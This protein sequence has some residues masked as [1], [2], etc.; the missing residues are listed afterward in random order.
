MWRSLWQVLRGGHG[1]RII[2]AVAGVFLG[3]LYL[4][5]G[6]WD[7]LM[8]AIIVCIAYFIGLTLDRGGLPFDL[9]PFIAWLTERW[10]GFK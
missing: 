9:R 6:F 1:G 4:F 5:T 2:G 8:F 7:M 3:F 10:R